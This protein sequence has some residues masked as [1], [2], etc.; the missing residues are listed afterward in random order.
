MADTTARDN[1][2]QRLWPGA[3]PGKTDTGAEQAADPAPGGMNAAIR[4]ATGRQ[5]EQ[6]GS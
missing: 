4:R 2:R 5:Q 6:E 3:S 1:L